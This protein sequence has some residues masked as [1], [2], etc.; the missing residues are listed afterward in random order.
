[1]EKLVSKEQFMERKIGLWINNHKAV[2][3]SIANKKIYVREIISNIE[4]DT[5]LSNSIQ[6]DTPVESQGV[7]A[8][9]FRDPQVEIL[10]DRYYD[11]IISLINDA[12]SIWIFGPDEAK[13][14]LEDRLRNA[15]FGARVVGIEAMAEMTNR[16]LALKVQQRFLRK[17]VANGHSKYSLNND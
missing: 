7:S 13:V 4:K 6:P 16:Q 3:V 12:E 9:T 1:L 15:G 14:E 2:I 11:V 17:R 8:E 10:Q 5:H